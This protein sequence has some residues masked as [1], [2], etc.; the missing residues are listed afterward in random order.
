LRGCGEGRPPRVR[1]LSR[2]G[3]CK[4]RPA[5][6]RAHGRRQEKYTPDPPL[7]VFFMSQIRQC[8]ETDL[9]KGLGAFLWAGGSAPLCGRFEWCMLSC[10]PP[11][12]LPLQALDR[13]CPHLRFDRGARSSPNA[14][15]GAHCTAVHTPGCR[16]KHG[17]AGRTPAGGCRGLWGW[18]RRRGRCCDEAP[19]GL[20]SPICHANAHQQVVCVGFAVL[21]Q[22]GV[23]G[24]ERGGLRGGAAWTW[25]SRLPLGRRAPLAPAPA[26]GGARGVGRRDRRA[27][28]E[29]ICHSAPPA[30]GGPV[31]WPHRAP[32]RAAGAP[33]PAPGPQRKR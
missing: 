1:A 20:R 32:E 29:R 27:G 26:A 19:V 9:F 33:A 18:A 14:T 10:G 8:V 4:R 31:P 2:L 13:G 7:Q 3:P 12:Q 5:M 21:C 28:R 22:P 11:A 15:R 30:G 25:R 6:Q 23:E 17:T 16:S 24:G